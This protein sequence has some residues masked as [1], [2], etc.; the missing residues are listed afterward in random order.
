[1]GDP[2][3]CSWQGCLVPALVFGRCESSTC[4]SSEM[5]PPARVV[6]CP[7]G[8]SG[9][10][11]LPIRRRPTATRRGSNGGEATWSALAA[12][13]HLGSRVLSASAVIAYVAVSEQ[14]F[15][16]ARGLPPSAR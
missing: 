15:Q 3:T 2:D 11:R 10:G 6:P 5:P 12:L 1:M 9:V 4:S 8:R 7:S 13:P 16:A 14:L